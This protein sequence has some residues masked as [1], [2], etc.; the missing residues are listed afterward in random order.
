MPAR[1]SKRVCPHSVMRP[2]AGLRSPA[3]A[4]KIVVFP[5]AEGPN[6]TLSPGP[7]SSATS[8]LKATSFWPRSKPIWATNL[9]AALDSE[10]IAPLLRQVAD[11]DQHAHC[12][13]RHDQGK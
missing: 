6:S 3:I 1:P 5:E 7:K 8:R 2:R 4:D 12:Q 10:T 9:A 13:S 11:S